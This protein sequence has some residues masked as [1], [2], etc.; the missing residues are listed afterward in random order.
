MCQVR[1]DFESLQLQNA[2]RTSV[3]TTN[4]VIINNDD[5]NDGNDDDDDDEQAGECVVDQLQFVTSSG[6]T[7]GPI[8]G[9][10][11]DNSQ[12]LY[13]GNIFLC[14]GWVETLHQ[15]K[16]RLDGG[17][18]RVQCFPADLGYDSSDG[19]T[20]TF[21]T[22]TAAPTSTSSRSGRLCL[23]VIGNSNFIFNL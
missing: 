19:A 20:I 16:Q 17:C 8:C 3:P 10:E 7:F 15:I 5:V 9:T 2:V 21:K 6:D 4:Q 14:L 1:I 13:L 18:V 22:N 11:T 12:H 23:F